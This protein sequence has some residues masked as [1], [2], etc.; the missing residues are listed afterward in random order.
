V[1]ALRILF[2]LWVAVILQTTLAPVI[3]ILGVRPDFPL[4][5]V[6]LVA[7][8]EGAAGGALAGFVAGLFVDLNSTHALGAQSLANS[9]LAWGVGSFADRLVRDSGVARA[10]VALAGTA[11]RDV[12]LAIFLA[13]TGPGGAVRHLFLTA[14][15]GGLYTA[16]L[17]VPVM[18][19]A[20]R[21]IRW[22]RESGRGLS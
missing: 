15:P 12:A 19:L 22:G 17:A 10:G 7:L 13:P 6:L 14:I 5:V 3:A 4:L 8:R 18:M 1:R 2:V 9:L 16:L 20:E 21:G 11:L